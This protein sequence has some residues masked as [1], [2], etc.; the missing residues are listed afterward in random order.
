MTKKELKQMEEAK[1]MEQDA[2]RQ[3][4][5]NFLNELHN[6]YDDIEATTRYYKI[7]NMEDKFVS[8]YRQVLTKEEKKSL[9][10]RYGV[11][12]EIINYNGEREWDAVYTI[13]NTDR[14]YHD[15]RDRTIFQKDLTEDTLLI[16]DTIWDQEQF[17]RTIELAKKFGYT[18]VVYISGSTSAMEN[19][20]RF[21]KAGYKIVGT[22]AKMYR[23]FSGELVVD[24]EGIVVS[25]VD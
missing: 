3:L 5:R 21:I 17:D 1:R 6:W 8:K 13:N 11:L 12:K 4:R 22:N 9:F 23:Q 14:V 20:V 10:D 25:L 16:D 7:N 2:K 19:V 24:R 18:E 15:D